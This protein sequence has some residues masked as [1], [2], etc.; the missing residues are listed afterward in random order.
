MSK[1]TDD[2]IDPVDDNELSKAIRESFQAYDDDAGFDDDDGGF[3]SSLD[4]DAIGGDVSRVDEEEGRQKIQKARDK[5]FTGADDPLKDDGKP[6]VEGK[7]KPDTKKDED[8]PLGIKSKNVKTGVANNTEGNDDGAK[9]DE[10]SAEIA[11][12]DVDDAAYKEAIDGLP[13]SIR[14]RITKETAEASEVMSAF[15]G[16]EDQLKALG[17]DAKGAAK[18]FAQTHDYANRDPQGY[19][20]WFTQ[21]VSG[22][23]PTKVE[24]ILKG[25]AAKLGYD[26]TKSSSTDDDDDDPFMSESERQIIAENRALKAQLEQS[27]NKSAIP[28]FGPDSPME[29]G[30]RNL[31][32]FISE[33]NENGDPAHPNF[34]LL[35]EKI[36]MIVA[37]Q[38]KKNGDG[39]V[40]KEILKDA[41]SQAELMHPE[42][43]QSALQRMIDQEKNAA[44]RADHVAQVESN[45]AAAQQK[46]KAASTK[47]LDGA[48]QRTVRQPAEDDQNLSISELLRRSY[49]G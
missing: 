22:S 42:T 20:A 18:F 16:Q 44:Q 34:S 14:N 48:G 46:S 39:M 35:K 27:T 37:D 24:A 15:S 4:D 40:T 33:V 6:K 26:V 12:E 10:G 23:D 47:I 31:T 45:N 38:V 13:E 9:G 43:R 32:S 28:E 1:N 41:Y 19:M 49:K 29:V 7:P 11:A 30:T 17:T 8:D 5:V 21:Q 25:A 36:T 3:G 2:L